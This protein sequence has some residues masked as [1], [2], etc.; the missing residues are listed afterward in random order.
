[1]RELAP[2]KLKILDDNSFITK[3]NVRPVTSQLIRESST[4]MFHPDGLFSETIFGQIASPNRM[5][6][7]GY[8]NLRTRILHPRVYD[9]LIRLNR[10]FADVMAGT[11]YMRFDPEEGTYVKALDTEDG[12]GTGYAF[13]MTA[14]PK[15]RLD[16]NQSL[17][18]NNRIDMISK[19]RKEMVMSKL[20]VLPAGL[21]DIKIDDTMLESDSINSIYMTIMSY[22][23]AFPTDP[24]EN[25][26][27]NSVRY[28][29]QKKVIEL[30]EYIENVMAGG[31]GYLERK[32]FSRQIAYGTRNVIS[33]ASMTSNKSDDADFFKC[34]ETKLPL[35]QACGSGKPLVIYQMKR[36]FFGPTF[37]AS[38]EQIPV[39]DP[40][41]KTVVYIRISEDEKNKFMTSDGLNDMINLC[42]N[43]S[44]MWSPVTVTSL[45]DKKQYPLVMVYDTNGVVMTK[46]KLV[47]PE[48]GMDAAAIVKKL[49]DNNLV[50]DVIVGVGAAMVLH[51]YK[52]KT[53]DIDCTAINF[54]ALVKRFNVP[55]AKSR[56]GSRMIT[57][58][59]NVE[60]FDGEPP[61]HTVVSGVKTETIDSLKEFFRRSGRPK[62]VESLKVLNPVIAK[63]KPIIYV[64][65]SINELME[66][67][68]KANMVFDAKYLRYLTYCELIYISAT[69]A[70]K[71][72]CCSVTR[73]PI[74]GLQSMVITKLKVATT[75]PSR[76]VSLGLFGADPVSVLDLA[77]YPVIK[78]TLLKSMA[79][80][81]AYLEGLG[82]DF[83]GDTASELS[84]L[85]DDS[86]AECLQYLESKHSIISD[87][88]KLAIGSATAMTKMMF[89]NLT[90]DPA[91]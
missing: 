61:S 41:K 60:I 11:A 47:G 44:V 21:R 25:P 13:F 2:F 3:N 29:L 78:E 16:K 67:L 8:I 30:F 54:D 49:T 36:L 28:A 71:D 75:E 45:D 33:S 5:G 91:E 89:F 22:A 55:V 87:S 38:T 65:K 79:I 42:Q 73:Y 88:G 40:E 1:M 37:T 20:L 26:L 59:E 84:I 64:V 69:L 52:T 82:G 77:N 27:Y 9:A 12:A 43:T 76:H 31:T 39:V 24:C 56:L 35:I 15:I 46:R 63:S 23:R 57:I 50:N 66:S 90:M 74:T 10:L 70:F 34:D 6:T 14:L 86:N 72:K 83:D 53:H 51:G 80:H 68:N 85:S 58:A 7:F 19:Y 48:D 62:D 4:N 32:F 17:S 18:R 81:P